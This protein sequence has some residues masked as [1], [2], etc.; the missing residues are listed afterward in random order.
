MAKISEL[1]N[2]Q[3]EKA[4]LKYQSEAKKNPSVKIKA[5]LTQLQ[6]ERQARLATPPE[7]QDESELAKLTRSAEQSMRMK[8]IKDAKK[9]P[10]L[11]QRTK[12]GPGPNISR[13]KGNLLLFSGIAIGVVGLLL[14]ADDLLTEFIYFQHKMTLSIILV[15]IGI[16]LS[17]LSSTLMDDNR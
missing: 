14:L 3:L 8:Q 7:E 4:Y 9:Q 2:S 15:L 1:S 10:K 11:S 12:K 17:K 6:K 5:I 16:A 13:L